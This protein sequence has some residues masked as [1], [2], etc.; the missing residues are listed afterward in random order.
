MCQFKFHVDLSLL[1][2]DTS[3]YRW[4]EV[5]YAT[6]RGGDRN[7]RHHTFATR[8]PETERPGSVVI[9]GD[10]GKI[11]I[12]IMWCVL[13]LVLPPES[14]SG[15]LSFTLKYFLFFPCSITHRVRA[16]DITTYF[17]FHVYYSSPYIYVGKASGYDGICGR[18]T[19]VSSSD[20]SYLL[21]IFDLL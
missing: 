10:P 14:S 6:G 3:F 4:T 16:H 12:V 5:L 20:C 8:R 18:K 19:I 17:R 7:G 11:K 21:Y 13:R 1:G 2:L 15:I 9:R